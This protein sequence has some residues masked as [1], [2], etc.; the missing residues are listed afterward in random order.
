VVGYTDADF[1]GDKLAR[2]STS[3]MVFLMNGGA[4]SWASKL[5]ATVATSTCEAE[6]IAGALAV[7]ECLYISK[8]IA[9]VTG[10]YKALDLYG[11][12]QAALMLL[13][14][15]HAGAQNR[16]KHVDI[17]Y[18]FARHRVM[19]G[20]VN[21]HFISTS[22]MVADIMTKQLSGPAFRKH[23]ESLGLCVLSRLSE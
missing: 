8:V 9:D 22:E 15:V 2:K 12:N 14:N 13:R 18:N 3:G 17:A 10:E 23:R 20:E 4:V 7:K 5:Q 19:L 16:T 1:A 6:L 21:V 11:D